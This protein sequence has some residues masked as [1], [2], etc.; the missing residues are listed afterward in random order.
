[1]ASLRR[2]AEGDRR[3]AGEAGLAWALAGAAALALDGDIAAEEEGGP[4]AELCSKAANNCC[5]L[6]LSVLATIL[7]LRGRPLRLIA[8]A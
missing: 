8:Q 2:A 5:C 7:I 6:A 4:D 1:M 3:G